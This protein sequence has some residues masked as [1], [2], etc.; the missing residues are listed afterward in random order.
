MCSESLCHIQ[1]YPN[2]HKQYPHCLIIT[3]D[4]KLQVHKITSDALIVS[5]IK[6]HNNHIEHNSSSLTVVPHKIFTT[7]F[8]KKNHLNHFQTG[9]KSRKTKDEYHKIP[10]LC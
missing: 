5:T 3:V 1:N 2:V 9:S 8:I 10:D 7:Q 6:N 4:K